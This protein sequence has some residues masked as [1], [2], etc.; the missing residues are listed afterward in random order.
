MRSSAESSGERN[1]SYAASAAV[2]LGPTERGE[3]GGLAA[4]QI[5]IARRE[6][7]AGRRGGERARRCRR[8][9]RAR[10][11]TSPTPPSSAARARRTPSRARPPRPTARPARAH[12]PRP[13]RAPAGPGAR[14]QRAGLG[15]QRER[16]VGPALLGRD[17]AELD[18]DH[19]PGARSS[20]ARCARASAASSTVRASSSRSV[21]VRDQRHAVLVEALP[22]GPRRGLRRPV[23]E[24]DAGL[25]DQRDR[26]RLARIELDVARARRAPAMNAC[27][28]VGARRAADL[29]LHRE[30]AAAVAQ[31]RGH[32]QR[33]LRRRQRGRHVEARS[34][35]PAPRAPRASG[36]RSACGT[37]PS[38]AARGRA[39][40]VDDERAQHVRVLVVRIG[41]VGE[42]RR[43]EP[44]AAPRRRPRPRPRCPGCRARRRGTDGRRAGCGSRRRARPASRA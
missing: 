37:S 16:I 30:R 4:Q 14:Q 12:R 11:R 41:L 10:A 13:R 29:G 24:L 34:A 15:D 7:E 36:S 35:W 25:G 44:L 20:L 42:P 33:Q 32:R 22:G 27:P 39:V 43:R 2:G 19:R 5:R 1:R 17:P 26:L 9:S 8:P 28:T 40:L 3:R 23:P 21:T 6:L 31:P 18:E 38:R